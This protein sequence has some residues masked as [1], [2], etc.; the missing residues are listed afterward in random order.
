MPNDWLTIHWGETLRDDI[1][2]LLTDLCVGWGYCNYSVCGEDLLRRGSGVVTA[3]AVAQATLDAEGDSASCRSPAVERLFIY[4]YG[5]PSISE[6]DFARR[7]GAPYSV[8]P[9]REEAPEDPVLASARA[10]LSAPVS[11]RARTVPSLDAAAVMCSIRRVRSRNAFAL[12]LQEHEE[13]REDLRA[14]IIVHERLTGICW[15]S[16]PEGRLKLGLGQQMEA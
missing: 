4:R 9:E 12:G 11:L 8:V 3:A 13:D 16:D 5:A 15:N 14:L 1:E 6:E 7:S 10:L 2:L